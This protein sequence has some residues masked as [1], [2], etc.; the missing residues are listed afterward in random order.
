MNG[1]SKQLATNFLL[2]V[3]WNDDVSVVK[4]AVSQIA[5]VCQH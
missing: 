2:H 1:K 3:F 4:N 5:L